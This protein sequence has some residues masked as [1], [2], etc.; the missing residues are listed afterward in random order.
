MWCIQNTKSRI[1]CFAR[2]SS[3]S[4]VRATPAGRWSS[5]MISRGATRHG[6]WFCTHSR[7]SPRCKTSSW[8][9]CRP[10]LSWNMACAMR[11]SRLARCRNASASRISTLRDN[12]T[13]SGR[14][15]KVHLSRRRDD[16]ASRSPSHGGRLSWKCV[17]FSRRREKLTSPRSSRR[18]RE[19]FDHRPTRTR[20]T[21]RRAPGHRSADKQCEWIL[22]P[23]SSRPG[24][25]GGYGSRLHDEC[26]CHLHWM[27]PATAKGGSL[28]VRG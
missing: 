14:R 27:R 17:N 20:T 1:K 16:S 2:Y 26:C 22:R 15:E 5:P 10:R 19:R 24:A 21:G 9:R 23:T 25:V 3:Q 18:G 6:Y 4:M 11:D 13:R 12:F 8:L 28:C 7:M